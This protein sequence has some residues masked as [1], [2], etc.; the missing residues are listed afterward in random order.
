MVADVAAPPARV[1]S[2][3]DHPEARENGVA[4]DQDDWLRSMQ[5]WEETS[6]VSSGSDIDELAENFNDQ[7]GPLPGFGGGHS[8][9]NG[10]ERPGV[11]G[12][13]SSGPR[14]GQGWQREQAPR[15]PTQA[16]REPVWVAVEAAPAR[17]PQRVP[18]QVGVHAVAPG[19][20]VARGPVAPCGPR[21]VPG[22]PRVQMLSEQ[23]PVRRVAGAPRVQMLSA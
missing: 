4:G 1:P 19:G 8:A 11:P 5:E 10:V 2:E 17:V 14:V 20:F 18:A 23:P 16:S 13:A 15:S 7:L 6:S 22:A 3:E 9:G 21:I 12:Q